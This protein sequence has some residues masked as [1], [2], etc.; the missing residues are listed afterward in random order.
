MISRYSH[1]HFQAPQLL[2]TLLFTCRNQTCAIAV[3]I[4]VKPVNLTTYRIG[5][6]QPSQ[7]QRPRQDSTQV[8]HIQI[9]SAVHWR[10]RFP[11]QQKPDLQQKRSLFPVP[12]SEEI[13]LSSPN[14]KSI[15]F[16]VS[17]YV[18]MPLPSLTTRYVYTCTHSQHLK[19]CSWRK[20]LPQKSLRNHNATNL[21]VQFYLTF[22][23]PS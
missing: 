15:N 8:H 19:P 22:S 18:W 5:L 7:N 12:T 10:L 21:S 9:L 11:S 3:V 1:N 13:P 16:S 4:K 2:K 6:F 17:I 14:L 23:Q 20:F